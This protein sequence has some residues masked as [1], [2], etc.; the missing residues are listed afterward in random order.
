MREIKFR[1][2]TIEPLVSGENWIYTDDEMPEIYLNHVD[3]LAYINMQAVRYDSVTQCTGFKDINGRE[4]YEGDIVLTSLGQK[5]VVKYYKLYAGYIPFVSDGGC[6]CCSDDFTRYNPE[7]VK[8]IG[9]I[10]EN[11]ELLEDA[12]N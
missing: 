4:I 10:F 7:H 3:K 11:P 2:I 8:V 1:G 6:G 12:D 5:I 9:N